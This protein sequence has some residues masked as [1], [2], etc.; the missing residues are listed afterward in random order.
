MPFFQTKS[1]LFQLF[2]GLFELNHQSKNISRKG[3]QIAFNYIESDCRLRVLNKKFTSSPQNPLHISEL[4]REGF[5]HLTPLTHLV[6]NINHCTTLPHQLHHLE[7]LSCISFLR[8]SSFNTHFHLSSMSFIFWTTYLYI[9][10]LFTGFRASSTSPK[11]LPYFILLYIRSNVSWSSSHSLYL[12][13]CPKN[14]CL[15]SQL[16]KNPLGFLCKPFLN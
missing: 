11:C 9:H 15:I 10:P 3:Y 7:T 14:N 6:F 2:Y 16:S 8:S 12:V 13:K 4:T 1:I 5:S